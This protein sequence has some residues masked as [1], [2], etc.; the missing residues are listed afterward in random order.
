MIKPPKHY[1]F[2]HQEIHPGDV[3]GYGVRNGGT[4]GKLGLMI[5]RKLMEKSIVGDIVTGNWYEHYR[6][7]RYTTPTL[8]KGRLVK[9]EHAVITKMTEEDLMQRLQAINDANKKFEPEESQDIDFENGLPKIQHIDRG[10][11]PDIHIVSPFTHKFLQ[12][13]L[14]TWLETSE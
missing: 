12:D 13:Y 8:K 4:R 10:A 1:D 3:L 5:V 9:P 11:E 6:T 7:G 2:L 14:A